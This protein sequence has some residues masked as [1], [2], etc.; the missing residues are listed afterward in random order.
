M[1]F[2]VFRQEDLTDQTAKNISKNGE[3]INI[4]EADVSMHL[5]EEVD[6]LNLKGNEKTLVA[7]MILRNI[8]MDI[9]NLF[10]K[11]E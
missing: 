11:E 8:I 2:R 5:V 4:I 7:M 1:K 6:K 10:V 3:K 9:H